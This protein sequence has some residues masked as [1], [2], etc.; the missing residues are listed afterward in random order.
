[1]TGVRER[2][3]KIQRPWSVYR[4]NTFELSDEMIGLALAGTGGP[5]GC[6][7]LEMLR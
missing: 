4:A 5:G 6:H 2:G 3:S 1:M 7:Y